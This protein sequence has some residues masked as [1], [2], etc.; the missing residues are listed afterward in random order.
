MPALTELQETVASVVEAAN[1]KEAPGPDWTEEELEQWLAER[2]QDAPGPFAGKSRAE[3]MVLADRM[4][5]AYRGQSR[6]LGD[7]RTAIKKRL[8]E[9]AD[10]DVRQTDRIGQ[11]MERLENLL[12]LFASSY[13][14]EKER[15]IRLPGGDLK[16]IRGGPRLKLADDEVALEWVKREA[17]AEDY[18]E[19][20]TVLEKLDR[21]LL[22]KRL[23]RTEA[24]IVYEPT[25]ELL[26][27]LL[28]EDGNEHLVAYVEQQPDTFK[29][30]LKGETDDGNGDAD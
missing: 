14:G 18:N 19:L 22:T 9:L 6:L 12:Q 24:G 8:E 25:G 4:L 29:V 23:K 28:R 21:R 16:R 13:F 5:A 2:P 27:P 1:I 26:Q 10:W 11:G 7:V 20:V 17:P 15:T 3:A 30:T